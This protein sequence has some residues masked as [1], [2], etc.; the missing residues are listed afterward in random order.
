MR[1][2]DGTAAQGLL[3]H[4]RSWAAGMCWPKRASRTV[5][6]SHDASSSSRGKGQDQRERRGMK[7]LG[8]EDPGPRSG[9]AGPG[10][11]L[12][13]AEGGKEMR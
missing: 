4:S 11:G 9:D 8:R 1:L 5:P 7:I 10:K 6:V 13:A 2:T 12:E 3:A